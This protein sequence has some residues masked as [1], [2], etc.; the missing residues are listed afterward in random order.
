MSVFFS[1]RK[2]V[3]KSFLDTSSIA[4]Y[5]SSFL[6]FF[7]LQSWPLLDTWW[8][9]RESSYL[10]DSFST[11]NGSIEIFLAFCWFF[12]RQI[13]DNCICRRLLCLTPVSPSLNR[14][15]S[16]CMHYFSHVL[17]ILITFV[18]IVSCFSFS[19]RSMVPCS[20]SFYALWQSC[21]KGGEIWEL[22]VIPQGK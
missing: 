20:F 8:I 2:I 10:L 9:D 19:C 13:L 14:S 22:N 17:H 4:S 16:S 21:Q 3:L 15:R 5:L 6:S 12:P 11:P 7:L 18:S 1:S